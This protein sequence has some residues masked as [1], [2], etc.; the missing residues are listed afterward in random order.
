M[1]GFLLSITTARS[2]SD[3]SRLE[4]TG[5]FS[6]LFSLVFAAAAATELFLRVPRTLSG[7]CLLPCVCRV[8]I[9]YDSPSVASK[10]CRDLIG[11]LL[12]V[13]PEH[14][15]TLPSLRLHPWIVRHRRAATTQ[16]FASPL[17]M[18]S[19]DSDEDRVDRAGSGS[20][21]GMVWVHRW[22]MCTM[23]PSHE[24]R[25]IARRAT[26]VSC[27]VLPCPPDR[28]SKTKAQAAARHTKHATRVGWEPSEKAVHPSPSGA[29]APSRKPAPPNGDDTLSVQEAGVDGDVELPH[30]PAREATHAHT[31]TTTNTGANPHAKAN[32]VPDSSPG[33]G[34][35]TRKGVAARATTGSGGSGGSGP[36]SGSGTGSGSGSTRRH[37]AAHL[38]PPSLRM[39]KGG[40]WGDGWVAGGSNRVTPSGR[41]SPSS[42]PHSAPRDAAAAGGAASPGAT[43][44]SMAPAAG[45]VP[46]GDHGP[47]RGTQSNTEPGG[48]SSTAVL[49]RRA[50]D[51]SL[52]KADTDSGYVWLDSV[53][54]CA[55][56][57]SSVPVLLVYEGCTLC[58]ARIPR[59]LFP[60]ALIFPVVLQPPAHP[61][62][63]VVAVSV[64]S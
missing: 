56:W 7:R 59:L 10:A 37:R 32:G 63:T 26:C 29:V 15:A 39:R 33:S 44:A 13:D 19:D 8:N 46:D 11:A 55:V 34:A 6:G 36:G 20:K 57:V 17:M 49:P 53:V 61:T 58:V 9:R 35:G 64:P 62:C 42:T 40:V 50:S 22:C 25:T 3:A 43:A 28:G 41:Q 51:L 54:V 30:A 18:D 2:L 4:A 47:H 23:A 48:N 1:D 45:P 14:R 5:A 21:P 31:N 52:R 38:V 24:P 16:L 60:H 27:L 12:T